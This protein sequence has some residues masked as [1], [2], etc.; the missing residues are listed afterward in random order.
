MP[1][2]GKNKFTKEQVIESFI[3]MHGT[4]SYGYNDI[5]YIDNLTP[6]KIYCFHHQEY[7]TQT[8]KSH[9]KGCGC[10]KCGRESQIK[11]A[12]KDD[13]KFIK[14]LIEIHGDIFDL[15]K[16]NYVN[17]KTEVEVIC[18]RHGSFSR[19]P[20]DLLDGLG[21]KEC[22]LNKSKYNN[23]ELFIK[24]SVKIFGDIIDYSKVGEISASTKVE[25]LCK[26]HNCTFNLMISNHLSGQKCPKCS[27]EHYTS[28][29][30]LP[31]EEY[32][33]RANEKHKNKYTYTNDYKNAKEDVTFYCPKHGENKRNSYSH[34]NGAGCIHCQSEDS[35]TDRLGKEGYIK[36][37]KGRMTSLY[38]IKCFNE[39]EEFYKIGKTFRGVGNRFTKRNMPYEYSLLFKYESEAEDIWDLEKELHEKYKKYKYKT[40]MTFEGHTECYTDKFPI[41]EI[42]KLNSN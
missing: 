28:I 4:D 3:K 32:Y 35:K 27:A 26:K 40:N 15:S 39:N 8:P 5:V 14:E 24:E 1:S 33:K 42:F 25:L 34:I 37:S 10:P 38:L 9:K 41:E 16:V 12:R 29:R 20:S 31:L 11:S 13:E 19:T 23:R 7:F 17:S 36:L 22:K 2:G 30:T 18:S 6:I 21:C